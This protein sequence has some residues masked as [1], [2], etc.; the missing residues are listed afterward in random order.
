MD[1]DEACVFHS[2]AGSS[3]GFPGLSI[4]SHFLEANQPDEP[5]VEV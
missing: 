2:S 4:V 3:D 1:S 5:N